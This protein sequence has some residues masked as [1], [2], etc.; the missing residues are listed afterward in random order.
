MSLRFL[1]NSFFVL[2]WFS[3][4]HVFG[5]YFSNYISNHQWNI[6]HK[7]GGA[8]AY[9]HNFLNSKNKLGVSINND[10]FESVTLEIMSE[11]TR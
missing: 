7:R 9:V 1:T 4:F 3:T 10:A 8:F 2:G 11:K 6:D 5:I